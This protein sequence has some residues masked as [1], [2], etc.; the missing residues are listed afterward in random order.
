MNG[1]RA[2]G[3]QRV[4]VCFSLRPGRLRWASALLSASVLSCFSPDIGSDD[5][6]P[7]TCLSSSLVLNADAMAE[8]DPCDATLCSLEPDGSVA[9]SYCIDPAGDGPWVTCTV[10]TGQDLTGF[11]ADHDGRG[12]LEVVI[13]TD[14]QINGALNLWYGTFPNRKY[15]T[16]VD[17][18][19]VLEAG[20]HLRY[21]TP[22]MACFPTFDPATMPDDVRAVAL[23]A[24]CSNQC[25]ATPSQCRIDFRRSPVTLAAEYPALPSA[26][27]LR[28][29]SIEYLSEGCFCR[30]RFF[31]D[32]ETRGQCRRDAAVGLACGE[33]EC[34]VCVPGGVADCGDLVGRYPD[35]PHGERSAAFVETFLVHHPSL[36]CPL[37]SGGSAF[38]HDVGGIDIQEFRQPD[39]SK[40]LT[41]I[42]V[43][44]LLYNAS[45]KRALLVFGTFWLAYRCLLDGGE[46]MGGTTLLGA[47]LG[48]QHLA[49]GEVRQGFERGWLTRAGAG[50][51]L[52]LAAHTDLD[53]DPALDCNDVGPIDIVNP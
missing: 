7:G 20:C 49:G 40:Q 48:E 45:L 39:P 33:G 47:P 34:G 14:E 52:Q 5:A 24:S 22:D 12:L 51:T 38:V 21:F 19:A 1:S 6:P 30:D 25:G 36:G 43:S 3:A 37:G 53:P 27:N 15:L 42:D 11:D 44:A 32:S 46:A 17:V 13:C 31:C 9:M 2:T 50:V 41:G 28:L 16:L 29:L 26:A 8:H 23:P 18:G 10:A 35:G 4:T